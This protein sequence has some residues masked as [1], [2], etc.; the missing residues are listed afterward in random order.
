M[1]KR[2][3]SVKV[4]APKVSKYTV[5]GDTLAEVR[6]N[7]DKREEWG[8]YDATQNFKSSAKVDPKGQIASVTIELNPEIEL[9]TW[10][11]YSQA[12]KPQKASWDAMLKKLTAHEYK[13]HDIQ[14][15]GAAA[16]KKAIESAKEL[17]EDAL[18]ALI[19][20]AQTD[21]QK[22]QD[23]YDSRSG[24]GAKEGVELDEDA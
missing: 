10:S 13:H 24:H 3:V 4:S 1:G 11:G 9:P 15:V 14:V 23:S 22:A 5:K 8:L 19:E 20:K 12:T 6:K 2:S 7:L 21:T 16:L 18:N 17:D